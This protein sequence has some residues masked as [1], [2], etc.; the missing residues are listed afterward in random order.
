[1]RA[2]RAYE[3]MRV[4]R[5]A[6]FAIRKTNFVVAEPMPGN[7]E[8]RQEFVAALDP[9]VGQLVRRIFDR[10]ELAG[11]AGPLLRIE[12]DIRDVVR[13]VYP[14]SPGPLLRQLDEDRWRD[15]EDEVLDAL[16]NYAERAADGRAFQRRLF[17]EDAARGLGFIGLCAKRYDIVLMN[18]PFGAF[19]QSVKDWAASAWPRTKNNIYAAFV[20]R[21]VR[22]LHPG[23]RLG[24]ITSRT[25]FFLSSFQKWREE[26]LLKEA[27]PVRRR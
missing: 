1:M 16:Q 21:G 17:A 3:E 8:L 24:A 13:E 11:E 23:G 19:T 12:D 10:M 26:T 18:P 22:L 7:A 2:Q 25:G 6:R 4:P 5:D 14:E 20:E 9:T 27:P 15:A